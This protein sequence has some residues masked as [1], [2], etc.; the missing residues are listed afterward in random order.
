MGPA[1]LAAIAAG[2]NLGGT[3]YQNEQNKELSAETRAWQQHMA[4]TSH[5]REVNDLRAAGLNPILSAGGGGAAVPPGATATMENMGEGI[6]KGIE[7]AMAMR[8]QNKELEGKDA[9]IANLEAETSNKQKTSNL[10]TAQTAATAKD[11]EQKTLQNEMLAKT[12]PAMIR[13]AQVEGD[14]AQVNQLMSVINSGASSA[15]SLINP[16]GLIGEVMKARKKVPVLDPILPKTPKGN[17]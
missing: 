12:L 10:L 4:S 1:L 16:A 8:M 11:V 9:M 7:T 17:P 14:W 3:Y 13:K 5:Q 15:A 6:S 2:S